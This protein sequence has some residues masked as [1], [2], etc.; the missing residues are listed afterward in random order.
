MIYYIKNNLIVVVEQSSVAVDRQLQDDSQ[1]EDA[2][3]FKE[4]ILEILP[5][6]F[7]NNDSIVDQL[8]QHVPVCKA[9]YVISE[10]LPEVN[11][12]LLEKREM[13]KFLN[14]AH[15]KNISDKIR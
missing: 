12:K 2:N 1:R 6:V 3:I 14:E 5:E 13:N 15:K 10:V 8:K 4:A 9:N 11:S 7:A